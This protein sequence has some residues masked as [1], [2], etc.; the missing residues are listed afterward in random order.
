M[1]FAMTPAQIQLSHSVRLMVHEWAFAFG[2][3]SDKQIEEVIERIDKV[4]EFFASRRK[5]DDAA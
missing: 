4:T 1:R 2:K 5:R 3:L